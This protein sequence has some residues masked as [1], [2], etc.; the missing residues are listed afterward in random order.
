MSK[1]PMNIN[2]VLPDDVRVYVETQVSSG[3]YNSI[4]WRL[5]IRINDIKH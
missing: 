3:T 4:G 2:I 5:L 1:I